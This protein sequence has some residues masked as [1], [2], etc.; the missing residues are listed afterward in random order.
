MR[1]VV[2]LKVARGATGDGPHE[3]ALVLQKSADGYITIQGHAPVAWAERHQCWQLFRRAAKSLLGLCE[4]NPVSVSLSEP[5]HSA[6]SDLGDV[7][8]Q[9]SHIVS[10]TLSPVPHEADTDREAERR[11]AA[12]AAANPTGGW[13]GGGPTPAPSGLYQPRASPLSSPQPARR[14]PPAARPQ[15]SGR[16]EMERLLAGLDEV[17]QSLERTQS[18]CEAIARR[19]ESPRAREGEDTDCASE[20]SRVERLLRVAESL[21]AQ[22]IS[23]QQQRRSPTP[24]GREFSVFSVST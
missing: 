21:T 24:S 16:R 7:F 10:L 12:R 6:V 1:K 23:Q 17:S 22:I 4:A 15:Q 13:Q 18:R 14:R 8:R 20:D 11:K 19:C 5:P 2:F 9:P 3:T